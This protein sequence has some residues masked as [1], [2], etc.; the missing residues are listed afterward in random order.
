MTELL[1]HGPSLVSSSVWK[2]FGPHQ[3][4]N[5]SQAWTITC[6]GF[7]LELLRI[8]FLFRF[9]A[10]I[11]LHVESKT[12]SIAWWSRKKEGSINAKSSLG[13][14]ILRDSIRYKNCLI[15]AINFVGAILVI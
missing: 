8:L 3:Y 9:P 1:Y 4:G 5:L 12:Q 10:I 6:L 7:I 2:P 14:A 15:E 11:L 13:F